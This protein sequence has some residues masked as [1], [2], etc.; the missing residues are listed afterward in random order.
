LRRFKSSATKVSPAAKPSTARYQNGAWEDSSPLTLARRQE[1]AANELLA[2]QEQMLLLGRKTARARTVGLVPVVVEPPGPDYRRLSWDRDRLPYA[3]RHCNDGLVEIA[4][5]R[6]VLVNKPRPPEAPARGSQAQISLWP[7]PPD[8]CNLTAMDRDLIG[9]GAHPP[10]PKWPG[11][12]RLAVNFVLNYEEGSEPS[13]P[14][15]DPASEWGLTENGMLNPGVKGRDLA[16]EGMFAYGSRVAFWRIMRMFAERNLPLTIFGCALALERHPPAAA[17][18]QAAGHDVCC[19]G[20]RWEKHFELSE[21]QERERIERAVASLQ[22]TMGARPLGWYCR[23]GPSLNTRKLLVEEGGFLYDSDAYDDE[24]PYWTTVQGK[25]HLVVPYSLSTNDSKFGR[26]T[27]ATGDDFFVYCRD[28][29]DFLLREGATQPK[30]MSI[31]L[32]MRIIGHP[33]R[34]AGLER[35][36]DH[37]S[38]A[39]G[40]WVTRRIDIARHWAATHPAA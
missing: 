9:Y 32:H 5:Q 6:D 38:N 35:L 33:A 1:V 21:A 37:I 24:L 34:A 31:G 12:A 40:A 23:Y 28:A 13:V 25:P 11:G 19:H 26:G 18:I 15:G 14:D 22:T 10:D 27:F 29:F 36:L 39:A 20:W 7:E 17:A 30:M 8:G 3:T 2:A 4:M 16:A